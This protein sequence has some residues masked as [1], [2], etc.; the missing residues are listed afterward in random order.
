MPLGMAHAKNILEQISKGA[1]SPPAEHR[2]ETKG[3]DASE[4]LQ[5]A[6][7]KYTLPVREKA[8][9]AYLP[10]AAG[11]AGQPRAR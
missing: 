5:V 6:A 11:S 8:R 1:R 9:L 4:A 7:K 2:A 10:R 3:A